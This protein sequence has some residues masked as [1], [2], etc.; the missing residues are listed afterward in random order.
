MTTS[1]KEN[2]SNPFFDIKEID[3][4]II[5]DGEYIH[6]NEETKNKTIFK[7]FNNLSQE[8]IQK[9]DSE[10]NPYPKYF[11]SI[12]AK[13]FKY[14]GI[15]TNELKR[16]IY[17][18]S[19]MDNE[20][21]F[22][23]EYKNQIREGLGI[24]KFKP[25]EEKEEIYIGEYINNK[26]EGKGIFMKINKYIKDD[27]NGNLVLINFDSNIGFFKDNVMNEGIN[28]SIK[29]GKETLYCGKFNDL[30]EQEDNEGLFIEDKNKIFK[31]KISEGKLFEGRNIFIND[32]YE[33]IKGYYFH[34][35]KN[36]KNEEH[37]EFDYNKNEEKDEEIIN[38][39]KELL[40]NN[41]AKKIQEI[42][43]L[44]NNEFN[45]FKNYEKAINVDFENDTKNKIKSE[46]DRI[47]MN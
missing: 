4:K 23:G 33:K 35:V 41:Y 8:D 40:E 28:F 11:C 26:K 12:S 15:L 18:Y 17:G 14:I 47:I 21:E 32:K 37:Y 45:L 29:D 38:K 44:I 39:T 22:L 6:Q 46:L 2:N 10:K 3:T 31:G 36:E 9:K 16:D 24:Y 42:F 13:N 5:S 19:F 34:I 20:D 1:T 7:F 30:G 25:S 43:D 27:S